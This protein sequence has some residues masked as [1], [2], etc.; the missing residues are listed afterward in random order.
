MVNL[1]HIQKFTKDQD[2]TFVESLSLRYL[3]HVLRSSSISAKAF[4]SD[5]LFV[6]QLPKWKVY[7]VYLIRMPL[8]MY[9]IL[10][11]FPPSYSKVD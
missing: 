9:L 8:L 7:S 3:C 11:Y 10:H 5:E 4:S 6:S 1:Y 2:D